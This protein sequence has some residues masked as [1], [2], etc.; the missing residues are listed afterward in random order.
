MTSPVGLP[1]PSVPAPPLC[2]WLLPPVSTVL[3][4]WMIAWR[5]GCTPNEMVAM[6]AIPASTDTGRSQLTLSRRT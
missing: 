6:I 4:A 2:G 1:L 5:N 3:L